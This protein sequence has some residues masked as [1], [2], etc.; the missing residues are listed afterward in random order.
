VKKISVSFAGVSHLSLVYGFCSAAQGCRVVFFDY[1]IDRI[2]EYKNGIFDINEPNLLE[3][4]KK[5]HKNINFTNNISE[6]NNTDIVFIAQDTKTN[7]KGTSNLKDLNFLANLVLEKVEKKQIIVFLSQIPPGFTRKYFSKHKKIYYQVE[8]LVFGDAVNRALNQERIIIGC[9]SINEKIDAKYLKYLNLFRCKILKMKYETAELAKISI[10]TFLASSITTANVLSEIASKVGANWNQISDALKLDKRIGPFA[11]LDPGLGISGGNLERDLKT[12]IQ[13]GSKLHTNTL[14]I[15]S[16]IS[17]SYYRKN[18]IYRSLKKSKLINKK[19]CI[20]GLS[21]KENTNSIKN[22][23][24]IFFLKKFKNI[25]IKVFDPLVKKIPLKKVI[26]CDS[27]KETIIDSDVLI[28]ATAWD[29]FK[30]EMTVKMINKYFSGRII[31]DPFD[32]LNKN[33]LN[34]KR[35]KIYTLK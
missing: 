15:K 28:I 31:I 21:Y 19:I 1:S 12:V 25:K 33:I 7:S 4:F 34:K 26:F 3:I 35:F 10:N 14:F 30:T 20:L 18:W 22:S 23:P 16:I 29:L 24:A 17:D 9:G 5:F 13:C 2:K 8:T 11:Y 6:I 32:V 27:I